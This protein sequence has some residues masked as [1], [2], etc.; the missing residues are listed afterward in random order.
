MK[1]LKR[2][3]FLEMPAGTIFAKGKPWYF[4]APE[5]KGDTTGDDFTAM[6]LCWIESGGDIDGERNQW[7]RL[8]LMLDDGASFPM[9]P[10]YGRDGCFD[11]EDIFLV[12]E[13]ADLLVLRSHVDAAL[14]LCRKTA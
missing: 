7:G 3:E 12:W 6:Q 14:A 2:G 8:T 13:E 4:E 1:I 10:D 9:N 5:V 11:D